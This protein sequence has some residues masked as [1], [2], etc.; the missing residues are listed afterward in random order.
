MQSLLPRDREAVPRRRARSECPF[1]GRFVDLARLRSHLRDVH[2]LASARLDQIL[3]SA[4]RA[5]LR[6]RTRTASQ[7]GF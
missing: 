7:W 1:C 2:Q 6:G 5:A 3:A 4:R